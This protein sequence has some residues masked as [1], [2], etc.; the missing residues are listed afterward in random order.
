MVATAPINNVQLD[1]YQVSIAQYINFRRDGFL[2]VRDLVSPAEIAEL[3]QHTEDLMQGRLPEQQVTARHL[4]SSSGTVTVNDFGAPPAHLSPAEKAN[5]FLRIHMLHRQLELHERFM[6]HPRVLDVLEVLI[7]PDLLALQTMLFLKPAGSAG[8]GWHQ[9]SYYIPTHPDTLCGAW[10]AIDDCDERNGAMWFA[11]GSGNEPVYPP[12]PEVGYG[13]GEKLLSDIRYINGAS[14]TDD[15]KNALSP[16][17]D[18][19][20]QVLAPMKAGDVA[21]FNGHVLHRSKQNWSTDRFRRSFV[22]HY[23]NARSFTYWGSDESQP[24]KGKDPVTGGVNASH[25]LA[26]GNTHLPFAVPKF[27]TPCA[28][29]QPADERSRASEFAARTIASMNNGLMGCAIADPTVEHDH[30][31]DD[32][33]DAKAPSMG[34][35]MG[36]GM[37]GTMGGGMGGGMGMGGVK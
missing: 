15:T 18:R 5:F 14:N 32:D 26:R 34:G 21:F 9:D 17:A 16:I 30:H 2:I 1:R 3:R 7:G 4:D 8:Q 25:I 36:G 33:A 24:N 6:L 37:G 35:T 20:D 28:A 22:S 19:Y 10:I 13:F 29:L 12:C 27:G 23:C 31:D 11:K